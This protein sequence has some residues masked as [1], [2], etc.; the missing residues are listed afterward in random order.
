METELV[1]KKFGGSIGVLFP[2]EILERQRIKVNDKIKVNVEKVADLGFMFGKGK[3]IKGSTQKMMDEI[4][5]GEY[6]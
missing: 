6:E 2:R 1:V 5:E 3:S 4:D